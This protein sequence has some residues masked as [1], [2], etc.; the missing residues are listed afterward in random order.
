MSELPVGAVEFYDNVL[1]ALEAGDYVL[2]VTQSVSGDG[3]SGTY[4]HDQAL[5]VTGPHFGL[6]AGDVFSVH[7]PAGSTADYTESLAN[8]VL[9]RRNLP[10]QIGDDDARGRPWLALL[11]LTPDEVVLPTV[12]ATVGATV[13]PGAGPAPAPTPTGTHTVT[14]ADY[15]TPPAGLL[16]P[17][18]SADR[19]AGFERE[20]PDLTCN[21]VDVSA[22]AFSATAPTAAELTLLAHARQIDTGDQEIL[23]VEADGWFSV[24]IGNRLAQGSRTGV[25]YAHLVSVEG[26]AASLPPATIAAGAVRLL[27]L[28]SWTFNGLESAGDFAGLMHD[29]DVGLLSLPPA[30]PDPGGDDE[31]LVARALAGGYTAVDYQTRLGERTIAWFRGPCLPVRM[32]HNPQTAYSDPEAALVYERGTGMFDTSY[33]V[34]WQVGRL[35]ALANRQVVTSLLRWLRDQH[36]MSQLLVHRLQLVG[37]HAG[38]GLPDD[39]DHLGDLLAPTLLRTLARRRLAGH[40]GRGLS[41]SAEHPLFGPTTDPSGLRAHVSRLPGLLGED[42]VRD[43]GAGGQDPTAGLLARLRAPAEPS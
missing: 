25:Y 31:L 37:R 35:L 39:L 34:A 41:T 8:V 3:I 19:V 7:P 29:L 30:L 13:G 32:E 11:L 1:P 18:F 15:L 5:Q 33:A 42:E 16:G 10:W 38:L 43:L 26:F 6:D 28:A 24:V 20:Y 36:R 4:T 27:S 23:G 17:A 21:V 2:T 12:G 9:S 22:E 40:L 14:L